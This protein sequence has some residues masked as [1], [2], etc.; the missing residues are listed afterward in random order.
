[1]DSFATH[2]FSAAAQAAQDEAGTLAKY[3]Q[4]YQTRLTDGLGPD[5]ADF[6]TSR[7][8]FYMASIVESGFPY[9]QHRGGPA[10]FVKVLD[11]DCIAFADYR[12]N[13]QFI[14]QGNLATNDKVSLFFMD[15][16]RKARLKMIGTA[17][18]VAA[19]DDPALAAQLAQDGQGPV[20][21]LVTMKVAAIDWNCPQY[22]TPRYTED[23][24]NQM[25]AP[26]MSEVDR[27]IDILA[28]RLRALGEDPVALLQNPKDPI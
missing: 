5:E 20:E 16:G 17:T 14:T 3:A 24:I 7:T 11:R 12:G 10:G 13:K 28:S 6:I 15:Y 18:M 25:L 19:S 23:E 27:Q 9:V 26:R 21:R 4:A 22:I 2:M 8:S 1:M